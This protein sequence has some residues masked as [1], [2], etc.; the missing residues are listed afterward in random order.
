[1]AVRG[2]GGREVEVRVQL[3]GLGPREQFG[4]VAGLFGRSAAWEAATPFVVHRHLKRRGSKRDTPHLIGPDVRSAFAALAVRELAARRGL[5][6]LASV[7]A[8]ESVGGVRAWAF[9]RGRDRVG[10]DGG[11]RACG[12]FR[13][14][15]TAEV[16]GPLSLGYAS[17]F[18]LGLFRPVF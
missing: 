2:S 5:P 14:R 18:G 3:I 8:L 1:V 12:W 7:E 11:R 17:H 6:G 13:L 9:R 15:F 16:A 4:E 10:D